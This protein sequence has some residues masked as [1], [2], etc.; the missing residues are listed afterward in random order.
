MNILMLSTGPG[1]QPFMCLHLNECLKRNARSRKALVQSDE[2]CHVWGGCM[3]ELGEVLKWAEHP[4]D[5]LP[6][7]QN[8]SLHLVWSRD[9]V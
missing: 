2:R 7:S 6:L 3:R 5:R 8:R 4:A 1:M 9:N